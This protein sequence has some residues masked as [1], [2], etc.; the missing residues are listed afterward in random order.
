MYSSDASD[1]LD[2]VSSADLLFDISDPIS[3]VLGAG[4]LLGIQ[5]VDDLLDG[6]GAIE[7]HGCRP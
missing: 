6:S 4:Q 5:E 7:D 3:T 1:L 2:V